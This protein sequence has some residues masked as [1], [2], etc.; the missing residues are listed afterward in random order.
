MST[1]YDYDY[2]II[3]SG[4]AGLTLAT[5]LGKAKK[6]VAITTG[7]SLGG[8]SLNSR[9]LPYR[10]NLDFSHAYYNTLNSP[11]IRGAS[12]PFNFPTLVAHQTHLV[13]SIGATYQ[14]TLDT[15]GVT[16]IPGE[17][18]FLDAHTIAVGERRLTSNFFIIAPEPRLRTSEISGLT[19]VNYL[20]PDTAMRIRRLPKFALIVGAGPTGVSIANF[21][22]E[23]GVK[24]LIMERGSRLL[25]QEDKET[26]AC[27]TAYFEKELGINVQ[28]GAKLVAIDEDQ[29]SGIAIFTKAGQEKMVRVDCIVLATGNI[30]NLDL[31]LE[32]A[33]VKYKRSGILTDKNF[34][35]TARN[36]FAFSSTMNT[37]YDATLLASFLLH[38]SR[39]A[40]R[41]S[42]PLRAIPTN[43]EIAVVGMNEHDLA[44][45]DLRAKRST[46]YLN[47]L[48]TSNPLDNEYGFVKL[49]ADS[50]GHLL[51]ATI[52]AQNASAYAGS[53]ALAITHHLSL[54]DL[55][56][57]PALPGTPAAAIALAARGLIR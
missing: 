10:I 57:T 7:H 2:L 18:N 20:T 25:P 9:A 15:L 14:K 1:K 43:P 44:T 38:N 22:A 17:A 32:N 11:A 55:L 52:V 30:P 37:E 36:I 31:G 35:T 24:T 29:T 41:A 8:A 34:T 6:R 56:T 51:G 5:I 33:G 49:L 26:S 16:T 27:L 47:A 48:P 3:G 23:L 21:Y 54:V 28:T 53:L 12:L 50:S 40:S 13:T 39:S 45:H 46:V 19:H 4:P 42:T